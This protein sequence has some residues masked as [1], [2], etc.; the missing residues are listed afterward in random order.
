M[1]AQQRHNIPYGYRVSFTGRV[2]ARSGGDG[3]RAPLCRT[4]ALLATT[5]NLL[6]TLAHQRGW[7]PGQ[8]SSLAFVGHGVDLTAVV[9]AAAGGIIG[10]RSGIL[11]LRR[12]PSAQE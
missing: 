12:P 7:S 1:I 10:I 8:L 4:C 3:V 5:W 11:A 6:T 2:G 9:L